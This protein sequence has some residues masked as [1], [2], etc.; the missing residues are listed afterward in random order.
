MCF[1]IK[2][3]NDKQQ[4]GL[5]LSDVS[6]AFDRV[7]A[8]RLQ[9]KINRT[10]LHPTL[11]IVFEAWLRRRIAYVIVHGEKSSV[12]TLENMIFQGS[13]LGPVFWNLYFTLTAD[14]QW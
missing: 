5:Y 12:I 14:V 8:E 4:V 3:F 7:C 6:G 1:W 13:V 11:A 9:Q 2:A 10:G